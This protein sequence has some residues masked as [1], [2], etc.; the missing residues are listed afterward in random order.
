M[1][2]NCQYRDT[3]RENRQYRDTEKSS[4]QIYNFCTTHTTQISSWYYYM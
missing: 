1:R 3:V 2:E 4:L